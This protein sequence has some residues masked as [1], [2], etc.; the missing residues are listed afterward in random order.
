VGG[1]P[2]IM[3]DATKPASTATWSLPPQAGV[4]AALAAVPKG[5]AV[6]HLDRD[7]LEG[8]LRD[9]TRYERCRIPKTTETRIDAVIYAGAALGVDVQTI[10]RNRPLEFCVEQIVRETSWVVELAVNRVSLTL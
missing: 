10:P 6:G 4:A 3:T 1:G 7:A 2:R 9:R 8:P 5:V